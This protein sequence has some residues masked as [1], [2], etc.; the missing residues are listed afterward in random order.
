MTTPDD[1]AAVASWVERLRTEYPEE[2]RALPEAEL[3]RRVRGLLSFA[4]VLAIETE[5]DIWRYVSVMAV[6]LTPE[7]LR[8]RLVACVVPRI[9]AAPDWDAEKRLDF[10]FEHIVGRPVAADDTD[11]GS[12]FV[13][14]ALSDTTQHMARY[15]FDGT[16][17]IVA[18]DTAG[19][20]VFQLIAGEESEA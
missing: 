15:P 8:S 16:P 10:L 11:F 20:T 14:T 12:S 18:M 1:A 17:G 9:L 19:L 7:Q 3:T 5:P 4:A 13:P 6:L 2:T